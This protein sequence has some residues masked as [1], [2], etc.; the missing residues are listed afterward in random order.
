MGCL[1]SRCK[2]EDNETSEPLIGTIHCFVCDKWFASN[3]EYNRHIPSCNRGK[4]FKKNILSIIK[5][6]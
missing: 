2:E 3:I 6:E 5:W 4:L 1:F